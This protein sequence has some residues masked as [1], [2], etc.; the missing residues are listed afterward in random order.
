MTALPDRLTYAMQKRGHSVHKAAQFAGV[1]SSSVYAILDGGTV[2]DRIRRRVVRY[3][4]GRWER[5]TFDDPV[6]QLRED[7]ALAMAM[8]NV[9]QKQLAKEARLSSGAVF[10]FINAKDD[11]GPSTRAKLRRWAAATIE[12]HREPPELAYPATIALI[13]YAHA[14][15]ETGDCDRCPHRVGCHDWMAQSKRNAAFC[16]RPTEDEARLVG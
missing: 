6:Q 11:F 10:E 12:A 2:Y 14:P 1:S 15:V 13:R 16:E 3:V 9:T 8:A 5:A 4:A 7:V